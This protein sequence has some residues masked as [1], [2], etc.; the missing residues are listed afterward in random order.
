MR[1]RLGCLAVLL[2]GALL[3]VPL[4]GDSR[5]SAAPAGMYPLQAAY[6][7]RVC[8]RVTGFEEATSTGEGSVSVGTR[9]YRI[10][11]G[12]RYLEMHVRVRVGDAR[13]ILAQVDADRRLTEFWAH[14]ADPERYGD[15]PIPA[16]RDHGVVTEF[17]APTATQD[18]RITL[19][20]GASSYPVARGSALPT[21]VLG[22]EIG[23]AMQLQPDGDAEVIGWSAGASM[24][25]HPG[26]AAYDGVCGRVAAIAIATPSA[27]GSVTAG[28]RTFVVAEGV[29]LGW[30]G[31]SRWGADPLVGV[32]VCVSGVR[33]SD[34]RLVSYTITDMFPM[35]AGLCGEV[36][37]L[38]AD[39]SHLR[40][41]SDTVGMSG[42]HRIRRG[43]PL[44][45]GFAGRTCFD[46][47]VASDG[48]AEIVRVQ[49]LDPVPA[50]PGRGRP[51]LVPPISKLP[52]TS[53]HAMLLDSSPIQREYPF[54]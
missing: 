37:A 53:T 54:D 32:D 49:G 30:G 47:L 4:H 36:L 27:P 16:L 52:S 5:V 1:T 51:R 35:N 7:L 25:A 26:A 44:P 31:V 22:R 19:D 13:C 46:R 24:G 45:E 2:T 20:A 18:G 6:A 15:W 8:G 9:S 43:T 21:R 3:L 39:R 28:D 41:A 12:G 11:P 50:P 40:L 48:V 42:R 34:G 10:A 23:I 33:A 29:Y 14:A 38:D 17:L